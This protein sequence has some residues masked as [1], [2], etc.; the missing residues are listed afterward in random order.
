MKVCVRR[1][2]KTGVFESE[3]EREG[4]EK[5]R[6]IHSSHKPKPSS[7]LLTN[8]PSPSFPLLLLSPSTQYNEAHLGYP[9]VGLCQTMTNMSNT[10][11]QNLVLANQDPRFGNAPGCLVIDIYNGMWDVWVGGWICGCVRGF[12]GMNL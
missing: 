10:P 1:I 7:I 11:I 4:R 5:E 6:P 9:R 12:V 3:R 2:D 8:L